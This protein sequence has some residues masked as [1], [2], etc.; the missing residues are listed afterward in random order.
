M[1]EPIAE[2][3]DASER[4]RHAGPKPPLDRRVLALIALGAVVII[5]LIVLVVYLVVANAGTPEPTP[6]PT[7][8]TPTQTSPSPTPTETTPPAAVCTNDTT[9]AALGTPD[10]AAGSTRVPIIFTNAGTAPCSLEGFPAV[11]FVGGGDGT[12]IGVPATQDTTTTPVTLVTIEPGATASAILTITTADVEGCTPTPSDGFRVAPPGSTEAFYIA[13]F[14]YE[15]CDSPDV[16]ILTVSAVAA[17]RSV[18]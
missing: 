2:P 12:Q 6:T 8:P 5:G 17:G 3:D 14:D 7:T 15:A 13:N 18:A 1:T 11:V 16:S 9:T 10:G 4:H